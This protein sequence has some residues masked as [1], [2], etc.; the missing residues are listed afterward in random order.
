MNISESIRM[1][2]R[3]LNANKL[4][5]GLTML[6]IIIGT[7][8]VIALISVGQ[9]AQSAITEQV[10]S[11]G[12]NLVF[13]FAGRFDQSTGGQGMR[14]Y[15]PLTMKEAEALDPSRTEYIAA[16]APQIERTANV[17][18]RNES[19]NVSVVGTTPE[20]QMVRSFEPEYGEFFTA[21][22]VSAIARVAVLGAD[23]AETLFG[24]VEDAL[25]QTI[26]I[27]RIPFQVVAILEKK[28]GQGF[29]GGSADNIVIIPISTAQKRLFAS[30]LGSEG[31]GRVDL[32]NISATD[33]ASI[34]PAIEEITWILREQRKIEFEEDDFT[35]T[36]QQDILGVFN[37][38]TNVLTIF[39]GAI[40]GISLLV[41][42]I[43]IMNIMLVSVTERTR[44]IGIRKA[45]G[46]KRSNILAQFLVE[47]VVLSVLGGAIGIGVGWAIAQAVNTLDAFT[48]RVSPQAVA[49]AFG[50]SLFVG[51]FFGIYPASRASNLNPI[52]ALRYE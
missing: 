45:V 47:S 28:G 11:I 51:L 30:R 34:D 41:G 20:F 37:Q 2:L 39:L 18:Y 48:T 38:I 36:S 40:A 49:L 8:A 25:Q 27:N 52:D 5:A 43:G 26:R 22:D 17:T 44:E 31:Q 16:V 35:V 14:S 24:A 33:E 7:G 46:A 1:A 13:V 23:T 6:G 21:S 4:R 12:S 50:F 29:G 32:I 15:A 3:S 19:S 10:Q 42:G 9:G